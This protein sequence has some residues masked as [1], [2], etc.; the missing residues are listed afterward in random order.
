MFLK[1][2]LQIVFSF[3][4]CMAFSVVF[5]APKK[6]LPF[7]GLCGSI[8]WAVFYIIK[9]SGDHIVLGT[10]LGTVAVTTAA[11][12]LSYARRAPSTMYH[13]AGILPLVPGMTMYNT[14]WGLLK[15]DM[16]YAYT[17][18][19]LVLNLAGVIG[20]GSLLVLALPYSTFEFIKITPKSEK[21]PKLK[22][23]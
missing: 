14:M 10:F 19:I 11:R 2:C 13:M 20:I 6:E 1:V 15:G 22:K 3:V 7:C 18:G 16:I 21:K 17:Q 8:S 4:A 9:S 12:F 23:K 5:N